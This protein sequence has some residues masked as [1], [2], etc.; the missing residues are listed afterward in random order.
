MRK[1][2]MTKRKESNSKSDNK[3]GNEK[4]FPGYPHY[5]KEEDIL[6][7]KENKT[8]RLPVDIENI[9]RNVDPQRTM[10]S[11]G[12]LNT[13]APDNTTAIIPPD[14]DGEV[15]L[16][17]GTEADVT[18]EDIRALGDTGMS[19]DMGDDE[20]LKNSVYPISSADEDM[21]IPGSELDDLSESLGS[22]DEEN[23]YYSLG[24]DNHESL[25]ENRE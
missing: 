11:A 3:S 13:P 25:E 24:G 14:P 5:D 6:N 22:E 19:M 16:V 20:V 17:P 8:E 4:E 9:S 23:N 12:E 2:L 18:A 1:N 15:D 10:K 7:T 21:D